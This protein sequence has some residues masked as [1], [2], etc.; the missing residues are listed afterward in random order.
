MYGF[1]Q[2][3]YL[4]NAAELLGHTQWMNREGNGNGLVVAGR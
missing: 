4:Y 3:R 2:N 1:K